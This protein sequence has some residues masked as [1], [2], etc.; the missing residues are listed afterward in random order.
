MQDVINGLLVVLVPMLLGY[1]LK[2]KSKNY[3]IKINQIVMFLLY[4]ILFLMG[5]LLG[6]LDDLEIKLPIIGKTAAALSAIILT[7]NMIGLMIYDCFNPAPLLKP[8]GKIPSHWHSL[9]DSFKLSGTVVLG[10]LCG[11][12]FNTYLVLPAG[13][14]LYV[15]I[16]LIFFVGIQLR[17]NGISLKEA[18][19]NKRGF[20]TGM[21]FTI[22]SLFGGIVA[23]LV[24]TMP[25]T[26]GLAFASGM[27]WYSL[28]SVVL[29]NAWGPI[30]GSIAF[31]NDLSREII[32]LFIVPIFMQ[33]FRSTAIGIT[34]ATA[35]DCTLPIIQ[36]S[37]GIEVTPIAISFGVVTNI[38]PPVL[39]VLFSGI[40]I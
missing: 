37:G 14:N 8:Q 27:G 22:T 9:A 20:Q 12:L 17:N 35:L 3:I 32:S 23:A 6:Q 13:I 1:L 21:V 25:I 15:L 11:W 7:S 19:F 30:Q 33:H 26:Q 16:A 18:L 29:T 40:P 36:K 10:T 31:F 28:S 4:V 5:Y 24:L 39:L 34:G 38:L 2:V